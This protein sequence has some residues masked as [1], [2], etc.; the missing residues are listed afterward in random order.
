MRPERATAIALSLALLAGCASAPP[1]NAPRIATSQPTAA[2]PADEP[3]TTP[4]TDL[5]VR[6]RRGMDLPPAGDHA[7]IDKWIAYYT[8]HRNH[9]LG[10]A[11]RARPF[12]WHIV[13]AIDDRGMPLELALLP[14]V[15][16]G[17][18]PQA[19][20]RS[21][22][23]GLWQF[24]PGTAR[25][26]GLETNW[27][28]AGRL[29][30]MAATQAALDY[31][32][33]LHGL[34]D[35]WMLA[36]AAYNCGENCVAAAVANARADDRPIDFW[37]LALPAQTEDYVPKLLAL[38][39]ILLQPQAYA[40]NWPK[41][42][43]RPLTELVALPTQVELPVAAKLVDLE[44][45]Q[46]RYLNPAFRHQV[47]GPGSQRSLLVPIAYADALRSALAS[48]DPDTLVTR[49]LHRVARGDT[50]SAIASHYDT[51]VAVIRAANG[52]SGDVIHPGENLTIPGAGPAAPDF[53]P[54]PAGHLVQHEVRSGQTLWGIAQRYQVSVDDLRSI[55]HLASHA[56]L[57][58]GQ[59]LRLRAPGQGTDRS[60]GLVVRHQVT[61]GQTLWGIAQHYDVDVDQ[62]RAWNQLSVGAVLHPGE[63]LSIRIPIDT[64]MMTYEVQ[65]GD[66]L[67][68]IAQ[69]FGVDV[70]Q[71]RSWNNLSGGI[72]HPGQE[73]RI[74]VTDAV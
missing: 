60:E 26:F 47:T 44:R 23:A 70:S 16:S 62:L 30:A 11:Q 50:L 69:R 36:V 21:G 7:R 12:L 27:W 65:G 31:L 48:A 45:E 49:H 14:I 9:L 20:S 71:L 17:F 2:T 55:N 29:D 40:L 22:A 19:Y 32:S 10:S 52:L 46:L 64:K 41:L 39:R 43:N 5:W 24:I 38:K 57:H 56:V 18:Q 4:A 25:R 13:A 54:V 15:E 58:P 63:S 66:T 72:I 51:S 35:N 61:R 28:Y 34:F 6:I 67:W 1:A 74:H 42:P 68:S 3:V 53:H 73:L 8:S 33:W 37:H 59:V